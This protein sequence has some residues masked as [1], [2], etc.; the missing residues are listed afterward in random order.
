MILGTLL[1][2]SFEPHTEDELRELYQGLDD[3]VL[4]ESSI[5]VTMF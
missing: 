1:V 2:N 3:L 4:K 5:M